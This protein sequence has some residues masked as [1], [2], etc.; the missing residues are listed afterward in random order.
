LISPWAKPGV[1]HR[2]ANTTDVLRTIEE[3]L[4]MQSLSQFDHFGRALREVWRTSPDLTP[5]T[6]IV[7]AQKLDELNPKRGTGARLS[8]GLDLRM[9]DMADEAL[10]NRVLWLDAKGADRP[11]PAPRRISQLELLRAH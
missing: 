5:W 3:L 10:F 2:F 7:P 1:W 4:G 8:Q 9:E 11:M 6:A